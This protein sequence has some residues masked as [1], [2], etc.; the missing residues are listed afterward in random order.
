MAPV[1]TLKVAVVFAELVS[2]TD[3]AVAVPT[4]MVPVCK[5][6]ILAVMVWPGVTLGVALVNVTTPVTELYVPTPKMTL[7]TVTLPVAKPGVSMRV[8][9]TLVA[10][11]LGELLIFAKLT[12]PVT[13]E[14]AGAL[15][16]NPAKLALISAE[17]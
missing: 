7:V 13:V 12:V 17:L 5:Y 14:P 8:T 9:V 3:V 6:V 4:T 16:G 11:E 15:A 10:V 2:F 1:T